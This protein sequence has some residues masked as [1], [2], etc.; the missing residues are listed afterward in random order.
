M[1]DWVGVTWYVEA[2]SE[3]PVCVDVVDFVRLEWVRMS[4]EDVWVNVDEFRLIF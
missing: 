2:V 3:A 4:T 1:G